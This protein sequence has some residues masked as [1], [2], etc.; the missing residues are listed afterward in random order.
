MYACGW[1][2]EIPEFACGS[3]GSL[4]LEVEHTHAVHL[5]ALE[6]EEGEGEGH[7]EVVVGPPHRHRPG[8]HRRWICLPN[9]ER[10]KGRADHQKLKVITNGVILHPTWHWCCYCKLGI[11]EVT[12]SGRF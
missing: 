6:V 4:D 11:S 2:G 5:E 1:R 3:C 7:A 10:N 9:R 8:A 12:M